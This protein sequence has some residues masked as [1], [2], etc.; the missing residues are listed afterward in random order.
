MTIAERIFQEVS[1][2]PET[3]AREFLDFVTVL[4]S[5]QRSGK[6]TERDMSAFDRFGAVYD[7]RFNRDELYDRKVLR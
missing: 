2:L 7:G 4:K 1:T 6:A 3:Q 5:R